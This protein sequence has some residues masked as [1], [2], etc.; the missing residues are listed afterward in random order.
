MNYVSWKD[1]MREIDQE[2]TMKLTL[3]KLMTGWVER[4]ETH[5]ALGKDKSLRLLQGL[6]GFRPSL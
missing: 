6:A 2:N 5:Q 1:F 4:R 3:D